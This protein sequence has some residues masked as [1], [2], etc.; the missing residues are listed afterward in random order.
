MLFALDIFSFVLDGHEQIA[1][2]GLSAVDE[3][4]ESPLGGPQQ[5]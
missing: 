2:F 5:V 4:P 3:N 1:G